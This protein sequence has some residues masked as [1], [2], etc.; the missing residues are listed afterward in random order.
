[1][2]D[3]PT[4]VCDKWHP[5]IERALQLQLAKFKSGLATGICMTKLA[6]E[7]G[8]SRPTLYRH[9]SFIESILS[10]SSASRRNPLPPLDESLRCRIGELEAKLSDAA[11]EIQMLRSTVALIFDTLA[12]HNSPVRALLSAELTKAQSTP[13]GRSISSSGYIT[14]SRVVRIVK[15]LT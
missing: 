11:Q 1:M 6:K 9:I 3:C 12:K 5:S 2:C 8:V 14:K 13:P 4:K 10:S 15:P 7:I